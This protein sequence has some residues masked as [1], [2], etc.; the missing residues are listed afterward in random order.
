MGT[1]HIGWGYRVWASRKNHKPCQAQA[2]KQEKKS[3]QKSITKELCKCDSRFLEGSFSVLSHEQEERFSLKAEYRALCKGANDLPRAEQHR[4]DC[5]AR[6]ESLTLA[7]CLG[8]LL[9]GALGWVWRAWSI[10]ELSSWECFSRAG[11][12]KRFILLHHRAQQAAA[13]KSQLRGR[14]RQAG[15]SIGTDALLLYVRPSH[16]LSSPAASLGDKQSL[17]LHY[18]MFSQGISL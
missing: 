5:W 13:C 15:E 12:Q 16:S 11:G 17:D 8:H 4:A 6:R 9:T 18:F 14:G 2:V 3:C 10:S 1:R 7:V